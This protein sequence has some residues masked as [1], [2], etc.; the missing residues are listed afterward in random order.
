MIYYRLIAIQE[1]GEEMY[2]GTTRD[3]EKAYEIR[4]RWMKEHEEH[5]DVVIE[6]V[7]VPAYR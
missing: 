2:I 4:A 3:I 6:R 5:R 1:T 7:E